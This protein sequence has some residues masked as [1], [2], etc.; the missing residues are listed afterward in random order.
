MPPPLHPAEGEGPSSPAPDLSVLVP[1]FQ[2]PESVARLLERLRAQTL[3]PARFE[4]VIVDDG[5]E[6]PLR[7]SIGSASER[8]ALTLLRQER[9]GP[10]AARNLALERCRGRWC[11]F[12]D[13][14]ALPASELLEQHL[15]LHAQRERAQLAP[16]AVLGS[17]HF[18]ARA[19][20]A[21]A[22]VELLDRSDLLFEFSALRHG[23]LHDGH[24]FSSCNL[25]VET[26]LVRAAGG[27]D[28]LRFPD[29]LA[30]V[31]LGL[32]LEARGVRVLHRSDLVAERDHVWERAEFFEHARERGVALAR[33]YA[34]HGATRGLRLN[35][36]EAAGGKLDGAFLRRLQATCESLHPAL[37]RIEA[38]LARVEDERRGKA[39]APELVRQLVGALERVRAFPESRGLL[40]ELTGDDPLPILDHGPRTGRLTSV[41]VVSFDAL[42]STRECIEALRRHSE[43]EHPIEILVVDNGSRDGSR[44]WLAAQDDLV[45]VANT[46]NAGA[47]RAR[48]QALARARGEFVVFLDNDVVVTPRW[49]SRLLFH[50]DVDP[51][52]ACI[53]P[54]C[55]RAAHGQQIEYGVDDSELDAFA[56]R[57][58]REHARQFRHG[59]LL[60]SFCLLVRRELVDPGSGVGGFDERF[61]PWGFEDDDFTL[62]AALAGGHNRVAL[63]VFVRHRA[64]GSTRKSVAHT[65]LLA[66]NWQRFAEKWQLPQGAAHGDYRALEPLFLHPP[67]R[68][69]LLVPLDTSASTE[70]EPAKAPLVGASPCAT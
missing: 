1:S 2:R 41:I 46:E 15:A 6:T 20:A 23:E 55:D 44:E 7:A 58:A 18:S 47:P 14:D 52:A 10:T 3:D 51:R 65:Q 27:F 19:V 53:G 31:D 38:V 64:Y 33:L 63:D 25:S 60:S 49:L 56:E 9:A 40:R 45:L 66:R 62:R 11:L 22:F 12:L 43:A 68:A 61:S 54:V 39:L 30:D 26:Q 69:R 24:A 36:G 57:R 29:V 48:N 67:E 34:K 17:S 4:V 16:V 37:A 21:S 28:A 35:P 8:F 42:A 13:D 59:S 5:S 32:R 70:S 50:A